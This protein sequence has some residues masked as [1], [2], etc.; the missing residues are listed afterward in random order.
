MC[1]IAHRVLTHHEPQAGLAMNGIEVEIGF[2][3]PPSGSGTVKQRHDTADPV[4][5]LNDAMYVIEQTTHRVLPT[6]VVPAR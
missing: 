3:H 2:F 5:G 1:A 6:L 4:S